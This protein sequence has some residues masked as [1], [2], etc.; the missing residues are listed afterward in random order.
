MGMKKKD[1]KALVDFRKRETNVI[2]KNNFIYVTTLLIS[3][4]Q[5]A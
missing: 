4:I 1:G 3:V 5:L 2:R